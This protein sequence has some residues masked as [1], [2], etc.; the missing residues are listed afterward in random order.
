VVAFHYQ[1]NEYL[2]S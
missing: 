1:N 2:R